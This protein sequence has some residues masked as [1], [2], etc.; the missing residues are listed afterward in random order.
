MIILKLP[1][2][3]SKHEQNAKLLAIRNFVQELYFNWLLDTILP[4]DDECLVFYD[5]FLIVQTFLLKIIL[6]CG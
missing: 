2:K 5:F 4:R 1:A 6:N 3:S